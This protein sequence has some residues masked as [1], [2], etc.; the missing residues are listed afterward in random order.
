MYEWQNVKKKK[1]KYNCFDE[2]YC[3]YGCQS[4]FGN[5]HNL[6]ECE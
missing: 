5:Y 4:K 1:K 3:E 2:N 6:K